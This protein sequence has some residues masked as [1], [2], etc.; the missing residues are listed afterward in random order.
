MQFTSTTILLLSAAVL[1]VSEAK[2]RTRG[3]PPLAGREQNPPRKMKSGKE[4]KKGGKKGGLGVA[5]AARALSGAHHC[6][7][8]ISDCDIQLVHDIVCAPGVDGPSL[9]GVDLDC[10]GFT[11]SGNHRITGIPTDRTVTVR[12]LEHIGVTL[13]NGAS[14]RNFNV[15]GL[16]ICVVN[17]GRDD[18]TDPEG[19]VNPVGVIES[20]M[21]SKCTDGIFLYGANNFELHD[22]AVIDN[23]AGLLYD[24]PDSQEGSIN[25]DMVT[26]CRNIAGDIGSTNQEP[27]SV[28]YKDVVCKDGDLCEDVDD[29]EVVACGFEAFCDA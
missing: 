25:L 20:V 1:A 29:E 4:G 3:E 28:F 6:G 11:I 21:V 17:D 5:E 2:Q 14:L 19:G 23:S 26:A 13:L 9:D 18:G 10:N 7:E 16:G 8:T 24:S 12:N 15:E 27:A 22:V